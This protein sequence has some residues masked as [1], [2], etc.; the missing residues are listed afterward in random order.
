M[1]SKKPIYKKP[2]EPIDSY[3][4][5]TWMGNDTPF[6]ETEYTGVFRDRYPCVPGHTL[7]IP[8]KNT[9]EY[10]GKSYE[11]ASQFGKDK[12]E[13][14]EI[15]GFN[16]GMNIGRCAGQTIM[17][18]HIHFIPRHKGDAKHLGG[19][20]YAHPGADHREMYFEEEK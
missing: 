12:I 20:R 10:I 19:M 7:F 5:S 15:A 1:Q 9:A 4:E 3:E 13:A 6:M 8:K 17:W 11:L 14:G 18:P 16:V 2:F